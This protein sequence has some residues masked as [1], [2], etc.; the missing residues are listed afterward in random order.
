MSQALDYPETLAT[1]R[2]AKGESLSRAWWAVVAR[3]LIHGLV[4][5]TWVSRIPSI[6][7]SLHLN[8]GVFGMTLLG[9]AVGS[10]IGVAAGPRLRILLPET[11][12]VWC[13][14]S[15]ALTESKTVTS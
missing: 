2:A 13:G 6:K 11:M 5:S 15:F 3:F 4:I 9:S 7:A 10:V 14:R 8:D 12:T 1:T